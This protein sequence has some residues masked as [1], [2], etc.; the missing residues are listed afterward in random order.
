VTERCYGR[1]GTVVACP[2]FG[3]HD[4][5]D[6]DVFIPEDGDDREDA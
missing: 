5:R 1:F 6:D 4:E 2:R 3:E